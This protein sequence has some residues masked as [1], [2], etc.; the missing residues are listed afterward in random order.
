MNVM[1]NLCDLVCFYLFEINYLGGG[2][3]GDRDLPFCNQS[4]PKFLKKTFHS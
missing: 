4:S 3:I 1:E 2:L